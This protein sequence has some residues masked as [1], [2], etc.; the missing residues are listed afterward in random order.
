[1]YLLEWRTLGVGVKMT[2]AINRVR[3]LPLCTMF[4]RPWCTRDRTKIQSKI[5]AQEDKAEGKRCCV[6]SRYAV[7]QVHTENGSASVATK[8][9]GISRYTRPNGQM[10]GE[11]ASCFCGNSSYSGNFTLR[12]Q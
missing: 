12:R 10:K 7:P 5:G 3:D 11:R 8:T 1:M 9:M 2:V 4:E 6:R